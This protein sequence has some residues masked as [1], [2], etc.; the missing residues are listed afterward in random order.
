MALA[1]VADLLTETLSYTLDF[2]QRSA[3]ECLQMC[4]LASN[5]ILKQMLQ[6]ACEDSKQFHGR[7]RQ[8]DQFLHICQFLK[9]PTA[10]RSVLDLAGLSQSLLKILANTE[11]SS[12]RDL[13][14]IAVITNQHLSRVSYY[15]SLSLFADLIGKPLV[16][17]DLSQII[18]ESEKRIERINHLAEDDLNPNMPWRPLLKI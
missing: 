14:L 9:E 16:G 15:S 10:S 3:A 17:E 5:A 6:E 1:T 12:I 18:Q 8:V 11:K 4:A 7:V 2:E 13:A